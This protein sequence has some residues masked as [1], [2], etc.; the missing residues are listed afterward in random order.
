M[1]E[2]FDKANVSLSIADHLELVQEN[3]ECMYFILCG[4]VKIGML[5][6]EEM[7]V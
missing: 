5:K 3:F 1:S 6:Y 7:G 2:H 4:D